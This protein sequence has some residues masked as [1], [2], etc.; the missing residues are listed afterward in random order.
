MSEADAA[1]FHKG[2]QVCLI[3]TQRDGKQTW[4]IEI[5]DN[6]APLSQPQSASKATEQPGTY[7][8]PDGQ[9]TQIASYVSQMAD[10]L[11]YCRTVAIQKLGDVDEETIRSSTATLFIAAQRKFNP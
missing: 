6:T 7:R 9:K 8:I 2:M 3:P 1:Q 5:L 11:Y 4:D 10:L